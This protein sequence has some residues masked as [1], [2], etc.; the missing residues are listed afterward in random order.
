VTSRVGIA[1]GGFDPRRDIA[2][3]ILNRWGHAYVKP[4]PWGLEVAIVDDK[5]LA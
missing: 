3:I 2:S 4:Q 1:P 5:Q